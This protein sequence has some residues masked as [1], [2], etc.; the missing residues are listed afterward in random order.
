MEDEFVARNW[1]GATD[2]VSMM[3]DIGEGGE[4]VAPLEVQQNCLEQFATTDF[5][6]EPGIFSTLKRY[7]QAGGNPEQVIEMLSEN[8]QAMAQMANLMAEWLILAGASINEVQA[9]VENHL[10]S[11]ILKTFDP[12]KADTIF[13][14]EGDAPSW[15]TDLIEHSTWRSVVYKLAEEFPDCLMLNFTIKL[16]SDA[17]F[18]GEI[19][20]ISTA[21][22]QIE[23]FSRILKTST[24][25]YLQ[26][27]DSARS[28][29]VREFAK[30]VCHGQ[31]TYLYAQVM[32]QILA[33]EPKGGSNVKRLQQEITKYAVGSGYNVTPIQLALCGAN[34]CPRAAMALVP[35]LTRNA[36]NPADI[37]L[38]YKLYSAPD[39]P[40]PDFLRIPQFLEL[41][42]DALFKPG[43][44]VNPEHKLKYFF[45]LAYAASVYETPKKGKK[46]G[47][48][49]K[50]DLKQT[51][52]AIEK[53][54]SICLGGRNAMELI[55]E[56]QTLYSCIRFPVVSVG[57]VR[58]VECVVKEPTFFKLCTE[59]VPTQLALLDEVVTLHP[60][61]HTPI[62][63]LLIELFESEQND[64]EIL[65]QL[66]VRKMLLDRM[67]HLLSRG[68]VIPV[69]SYIKSCTDKDDTDISLIRYFVRE[70]LEIVAAP[71]SLDFIKLFLPLV[72][73]DDIT[74]TIRSSDN[75]LVSQFI[76]QCQ[77]HFLVGS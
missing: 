49:C 46:P 51:Q 73:N 27:T 24:T 64:L 8:Y 9:M 10:K 31:H 13:N 66:E 33:Q 50:D 61:L 52:Q 54:H 16:I 45:L 37:T 55:A 63:Q 75:D 56:I 25:A 30:M 60:L 43:S 15:L 17:G 70:V 19:R 53:V 39:A 3:M 11:V 76:G 6:M 47:Q 5:I 44:K 2:S 41:L 14:E 57:V 48:V 36:L 72:E 28:T 40:P 69:M 22:Q 29:T 4:D 23:V 21:A 77:S 20:S 62:L 68:C 1:E 12:K 32:L 67:V 18:Q 35:M 65:V 71:Y 74:G 34:T 59:A 58:W 38:L 42:I 26:A 7:F